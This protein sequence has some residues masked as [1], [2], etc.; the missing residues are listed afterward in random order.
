MHKKYLIKSIINVVIVILK[1]LTACT[2]LTKEASEKETVDTAIVSEVETI[3]DSTNSD[4]EEGVT[5]PRTISHAFGETDGSGFLAEP[6]VAKMVGS[7][8]SNIL[9]SGLTG[10]VLVLV[11]DLIGQF[12]FDVRF[13]VGIITGI[14]G[15]PY[16]L[17]LLIRMNRTGGAA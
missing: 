8:F 15:A 12:A 17:Y 6:I 13:P 16:L 11:A 5:Y 3:V 14:L 9:P 4:T 1:M 7:S 2:G 10:A